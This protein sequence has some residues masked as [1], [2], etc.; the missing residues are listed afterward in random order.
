[1]GHY[2]F[3]QISSFG[4]LLN[5]ATDAVTVNKDSRLEH[6]QWWTRRCEQGRNHGWKVEGDQGL[7][8]N[9]GALAPRTRPE[10]GLGVSAGGGRPLP[11]W[12]PGYHPRKIFE[13]SDAKSCI[14]VA[15]SLISNNTCCEISY[16]L[17]T[18]AKKLGTNTLLV[19]QSKSWG[20]S[21]PRS[22]RL[23]AL[24]R[25]WVWV[26]KSKWR[27]FRIETLTCRRIHVVSSSR[28]T[29]LRVASD[30]LVNLQLSRSVWCSNFPRSRWDGSRS[31][32]KFHPDVHYNLTQA[33]D[34]FIAAA[35]MSGLQSRSFVELFGVLLHLET[36]R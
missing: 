10:A 28:L 23:L 3:L 21:L 12:G 17:K 4:K 30:Q 33:M 13:N 34:V 19:P 25:L 6:T 31:A 5:V 29:R 27:W 7:G 18:T 2:N 22:P 11:L 36:T 35:K 8:P 16:F 1:M 24:L 14:L 20:T 15:S 9:T 32:E 26:I